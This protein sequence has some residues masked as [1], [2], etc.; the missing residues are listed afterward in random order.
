MIVETSVCVLLL[1]QTKKLMAV[2]SLAGIIAPDHIPEGAGR[3]RI[4]AEGS[5]L[6][7]QGHGARPGLNEIAIAGGADPIDHHPG[8]P[9]HAEEAAGAAE[10]KGIHAGLAVGAIQ[11]T[12]LDWMGVMG[13]PPIRLGLWLVVVSVNVAPDV[14]PVA[15]MVAP[16]QSRL[17]RETSKVETAIDLD[18]R[19]CR[20]AHHAASAIRGGGN[21]DCIECGSI[22][23]FAVE[24]RVIVG[25]PRGSI[26]RRAWAIAGA[27]TENAS[28]TSG[29]KNPYRMPS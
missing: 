3:A 13:M 21:E 16:W 1:L 18:C 20:Q 12:I 4:A 15:S 22:V 9:G 26:D 17:T 8:H 10:M 2:E 7:R 6:D 5:I 29:Q 11:E 23:A 24:L 25:A 19:V 28:R 27:P 14:A